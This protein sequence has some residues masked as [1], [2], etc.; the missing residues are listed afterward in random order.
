M[1]IYIDTTK[2]NREGKALA[3]P[4]GYFKEVYRRSD[5]Y[6]KAA[7]AM[8]QQFNIKVRLD[9]SNVV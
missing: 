7:T 3:D 5:S 4:I 8:R 9:P 6:I 1:K 2:A